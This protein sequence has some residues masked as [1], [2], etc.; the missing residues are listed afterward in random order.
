MRRNNIITVLVLTTALAVTSLAGCGSNNDKDTQ[1]TTINTI[2][3]TETTTESNTETT[4]VETTPEA[5]PDTTAP[6]TTPVAS[7]P[8]AETTNKS[9][10]PTTTVPET[11]TGYT[12]TELS[13]TMYAKSS[14]NVRKGPEVSHERLGGLSKAEAVEVTGKCNETGWYRIKFKGKEGFVSESYLVSE[15]PE[16]TVTQSTTSN[17]ASSGNSGS[18]TQ[19]TEC[20]VIPGCENDDTYTFAGN[21]W[22]VIKANF[23]PTSGADVCPFKDYLFDPTYT[24][25]RK[26]TPGNGHYA[27]Y[28]G[29]YVLSVDNGPENGRISQ[30]YVEKMAAERGYETV[31]DMLNDIFYDKDSGIGS[32]FIVGDYGD[33]G[34]VVFFITR[35]VK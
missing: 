22:E 12:Y 17:T 6:E 33:V 24:E 32:A 31:V 5:E 23:D 21:Q 28:E 29:C 34:R 26:Y 19:E 25:I 27:Y 14:V 8:P 13:Q 35:V 11:P 20:P 3:E 18:A 9:D 15:K 30:R 4:P 10:E 2:A 16:T 7:E 1:T